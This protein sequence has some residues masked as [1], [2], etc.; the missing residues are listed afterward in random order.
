MRERSLPSWARRWASRSPC[1]RWSRGRSR[2]AT[3][4]S[5]RRP[6]PVGVDGYF[7]PIQLR[8]LLEHGHLQYP[9][10]PLTF[11][12]MAPFAAVTDPITGAKLGAAL[13]GALVALPAYAVGAPPRPRVAVPASSPPRSPRR[14]RARRICRSSSSRTASGS[15]S[16]FSRCGCCCAGRAPVARAAR[17]VPARPPRHVPRAQDGRGDRDR[18]RRPRA[19]RRRRRTRRPA[20]TAVAVHAPRHRGGRRR[21]DRARRPVPAALPVAARCRARQQ[22]WTGRAHWEARPS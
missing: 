7:Y 20:R 22:A 2:T 6:Y 21:R 18:D 3:S 8:S 9:P 5:P 1:R 13:L 11:W 12:L 15:R 16:A 4:S 10:S 14:A 17:R 19:R